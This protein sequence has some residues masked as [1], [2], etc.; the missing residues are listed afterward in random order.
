MNRLFTSRI[1]FKLFINNLKTYRAYMATFTIL[2]AAFFP[3]PILISLLRG[4]LSSEYSFEV[5][6]LVAIASMIFALVPFITQHY[7]TSKKAVD[8]YHSLP[9][10][11]KDLFI[12]QWV[13]GIVIALVPFA[14]NYIAGYFIGSIGGMLVPNNLLSSFFIYVI[15]MIAIQIPNHFVIMNTGT[16]ANSLVHSLIL[17]AAPFIAYGALAVFVEVFIYGLSSI[18][19]DVLN[20]LSP[21]YALYRLK[22]M[23]VGTGYVFG[24]CA[25]W[26]VLS[27]IFLILCLRLYQKRKSERSE[28][29]F[30]TNLYFPLVVS[31]F[32][33]LCLVAMTGLFTSFSSY[34]YSMNLEKFLSIETLMI[35]LMITF[36]MYVIL[37]IFRNR[38]TKNFLK[39][40]ISYLKIAVVTLS[41]C[42]VLIITNFFGYA[43]YVPNVSSVNSVSVNKS[44]LSESGIFQISQEYPSDVIK[45]TDT[46]AITEL[47]EFHREFLSR[48]GKYPEY[49]DSFDTQRML[50]EYPDTYGL[51]S[52]N[53]TG[54]VTT[55]LFQVKY[56]L[57]A[58]R[59]VTRAYDIPRHF[60]TDLYP[61]L[62][63][64]DYQKA[65]HPILDTVVTQ[66]TSLSVY[67]A[68]YSTRSNIALSSE[69]TTQLRNAYA[70]DLALLSAEDLAFKESTLKYVINYTAA[71]PS[72]FT[73]N[74][75][76]ISDS[77]F[78]DSRFT[79]TIA[80][81]EN[82]ITVSYSNPIKAY[83]VSH[84]KASNYDYTETLNFAAHGLIP[85]STYY[86]SE[87]N[88][89]V[90]FDTAGLTNAAILTA[91]D[92]AAIQPYVQGHHLRK[93]T[94]GVLIIVN[95]T[96]TVV[97]PVSSQFTLN[98]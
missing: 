31:L 19:I 71:L 85:V 13:T 5:I 83:Y 78:I 79:N 3:A 84:V 76:T 47:S 50:S 8:V 45:F 22:T 7:L 2:L 86:M 74:T 37:D 26:A 66:P 72:T 67:D 77:L 36:I 69:N 57:S 1:H 46:S 18:D 30:T 97:L 48:V 73:R 64:D 96:D 88:T 89:G 98:Q 9:I 43:N 44:V 70:A 53:D 10:S 56:Q 59:T 80:F 33:S 12:T 24:V 6:P 34:T 41:L 49:A 65:A 54:Y 29:P 23:D 16:V 61:L 32:T 25:Y 92:L 39:A 20:F 51:F 42:V 62:K 75:N 68:T 87:K 40:A 90:K 11:R 15:L 60:V 21:T 91:D 35:P 94:S 82:G 38:S 55:R 14:L 28:T 81:I 17:F 95:G 58:A 4:N 27:T 52:G 63:S 93:D